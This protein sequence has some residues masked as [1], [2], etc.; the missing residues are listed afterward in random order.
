[1]KMQNRMVFSRTVIASSLLLAF[2]GAYAEVDEMTQFTKPES[3]IS[4]GMGF[5]SDDTHRYGNYTGLRSR[6]GYA[7]IGLNVNARDDA[8]GIW[9][10]VQAQDLDANLDRENSSLRVDLSKQGV[11]GAYLDLNQISA[12]NQLDIR[13]RLDGIGGATITDTANPLVPIELKTVRERIGF[14]GSR[15]LTDTV[16]VSAR[17]QTEDKSGARFNGATSHVFA[18]EPIDSRTDQWEAKVGWNLANMN[19]YGGY[20]G[21]RYS[22]DFK[23][24]VNTGTTYSLAPDNFANQFFVGGGFNLGAVTRGSFKVSYTRAEQD[25]QFFTAP[26]A[27][28][29]TNLTSL[30][31]VLDTT[32]VSAGVTSRPM[33]NLELLGAVRYEDRDDKTPLYQ[34]ITTASS[35]RDGFNVPLSRTSTSGKFEAGYRLPA[36]YK[37]V[38]GIDYEQIKRTFPPAR[39]ASWR[40][41]NDE[42]G[43][44]IELRKLMSETLTGAIKY[45]HSERDGSD[46]LQAGSAA[47]ADVIAPM[48]FADRTRDK[49]RVSL[50]WTAT[51]AL[52][53]QFVA[54]YARD[55][56]DQRDPF[57]IGPDEATTGLLSVDASYAIS[58]DWALTG[59]VSHDQTSNKG[60]SCAVSGSGAFCGDTTAAAYQVWFSDL[61]LTG[62]AAGVGVK[63]AVTSKITLS[64]NV[65][66]SEVKADYDLT[67]GPS[68][69]NGATAVTPAVDLPSHTQRLIGLRLKADY[70]FDESVTYGLFAEYQRTKTDDWQWTDGNGGVYTYGANTTVSQPA[71]E[72]ATFVGVTAK[73]KWW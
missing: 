9:T 69:V 54:E 46:F 45:Q 68:A 14:G 70:A 7:S 1:M 67:N 43:G 8:T 16:D 2:G 21:S 24:V 26:N 28:G 61:K 50:D 52:A 51:D 66:Y 47:D 65:D 48:H 37:V 36:N 55:D 31:A 6:G 20:Y 73:Y 59:W 33:K 19:L 5:L 49:A 71:T 32:V 18:P 41:K 4:V 22:N 35:T 30:G 34:F 13:T 39:Q 64:A 12:Y 40:E 25:D 42:I 44:R 23:S 58:D 53:M 11:W 10:T 63:G 56:F 38:A 3:E 60:G 62:N 27:A 15:W 29:L 57:Q 17:F 72:N